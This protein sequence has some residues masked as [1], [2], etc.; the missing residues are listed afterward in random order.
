M[1]QTPDAGYSTQIAERI[2]QWAGPFLAF[3]V[4]LVIGTVLLLP[5]IR[6]WARRIEGGAANAALADEMAQMRERIAELELAA[7]SVH[8][9]EERL[10][11]AERLLAQRNDGP[12]LPLHRTPV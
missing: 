7:G 4:L 6:A 10:D 3:C 1:I 11:F 12:P 8:E 9:I 2:P 5:L